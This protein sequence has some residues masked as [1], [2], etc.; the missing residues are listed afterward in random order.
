MVLMPPFALAELL[1]LPMDFYQ[2]CKLSH[3]LI[4]NYLNDSLPSTLDTYPRYEFNPEIREQNKLKIHKSIQVLKSCLTNYHMNE[5]AISYNGGKD[6]LVMV[7]LL[8]YA[9]YDKVID[10]E[11]SGI[12]T[13]IDKFFT[14][15]YLQTHTIDSIYINSEDPFIQVSDFIKRSTEKYKLNAIS[16][17]SLLKEGFEQYLSNKPHIKAIII[18][19]RHSDPFG[20]TLDYEQET[21]HNWPKFVR[22]HPILH[23]N[24]VDVWDFILGCNIEYCVLYDMGYTSL[25]GIKNTLPNPYLK[26]EDE[27]LPAYLLVEDADD[28]ERM[29]RN[30]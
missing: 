18:G 5:I 23:W 26:V 3:Q 19:I 2:Q 14:K 1:E 13:E 27:Y 8:F 30:K 11:K 12:T 20:S 28:H 4:T 10:I 16:I 6:C 21:D 25:G 29:G 7:L 24:Y 22:I 17:K 15:S 9:I